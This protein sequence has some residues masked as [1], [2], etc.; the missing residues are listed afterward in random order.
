MCMVELRKMIVLVECAKSGTSALVNYLATHPEVFLGLQKEPRFFT[1]LS[2]RH[3][4]CPDIDG[5]LRLCC[6][7]RAPGIHHMTPA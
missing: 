4:S 7:N 6:T 5:F 1:E 2:K 3:W